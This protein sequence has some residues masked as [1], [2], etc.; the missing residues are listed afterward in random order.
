M[1]RVR[2]TR[3]RVGR[4]FLVVRRLNTA[5]D[6]K[7]MKGNPELAEEVET[8]TKG[9]GPPIGG[10]AS[11]PPRVGKLGPYALTPDPSPEGRGDGSLL[12][13]AP[14]LKLRSPRPAVPS[15]LVGISSPDPYRGTQ[16]QRTGRALPLR[17][18]PDPLP[19]G[20]GKCTGSKYVFRMGRDNG[21]SG[22]PTPKGIDRRG[23]DLPVTP[24]QRGLA[25]YDP[26]LRPRT[27]N[28]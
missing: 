17:P 22:A 20:E 19:R 14:S 28:T 3:Q 18:H 10:Q 13:K 26:A 7:D 4:G 16:Q 5:K 6:T 27:L 12:D 24:T 23:G 8:V 9:R 2:R 25:G 15:R 21:L 11:G 1:P